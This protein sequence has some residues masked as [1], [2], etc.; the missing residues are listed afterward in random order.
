MMQHDG[1]SVQAGPELLSV[2]VACLGQM[3]PCQPCGVAPYAV[4]GG[5]EKSAHFGE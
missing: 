1:I 5:P 3:G 4:D 2:H